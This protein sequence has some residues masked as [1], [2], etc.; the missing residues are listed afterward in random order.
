[1][2]TNRDLQAAISDAQAAHHANP[3]PAG[4]A[5]VK[6]AQNALQAFLLEGVTTHAEIK[7]GSVVA[8][9]REKAPG[10]YEIGGE[11]VGGARVY[12]EGESRE[13][14]VFNWNSKT[15]TTR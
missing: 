11:M 6:A 4:I 7:T 14:A 12:S 2:L 9:K 10:H 5:A 15:W 8:M 13:E 1:M 3:T